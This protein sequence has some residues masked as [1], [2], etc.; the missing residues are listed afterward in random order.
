MKA[1]L[2]GIGGTCEVR[3]RAGG[4]VEVEMRAPLIPKTR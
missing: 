2:E 1:R 4:G 3:N